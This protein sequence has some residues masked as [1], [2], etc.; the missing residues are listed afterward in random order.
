M[1]IAHTCIYPYE[2]E[3]KHSI[4]WNLIVAHWFPKGVNFLHQK[5]SDFGYCLQKTH[6]IKCDVVFFV[7]LISETYQVPGMVDKDT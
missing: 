7:Y 4:L 2:P 1:Y 6:F 5:F 3:F